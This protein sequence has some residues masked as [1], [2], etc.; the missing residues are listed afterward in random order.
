MT[1]SQ[2]ILIVDDCRSDRE[3]FRLYIQSSDINLQV[4]EASTF[5]EGL[6]LWHLHK[7]QITL[8][9]LSLP[10]G[11][12]MVFLS[13]IREEIA[14][15][16]NPNQK[17]P[18]VVLTGSEN[19]RDA[20][21]ALKLG[22]F[23]Y[24]VKNDINEFSLRYCIHGAI[25]HF[26]LTT[27]LENLRKRE[28][29]V[30][31]VALKVS[32][33]I[34]LEDICQT[35]V[36]EV[37]Q[38]L[39]ADRTLIYK[40][41]EQMKRRIVAESVAAPW[42]SCL[43]FG[44]ET[45]CV[46]PSE[47]QINEYL[48][49]KIYANP[50][51]HKAGFAECHL[52]MLE[53]FQVRANM[54]APIIL[55]GSISQQSQPILWGLMIV[56]HC[57]NTH[58]WEDFEI[59]LIQ[60][61]STQ[62]AIAIQQTELYRNL[63]NLNTSLEKQVQERT[64]ELQASQRKLRSIINAIPDMVNLVS[65]DGVYLECKR[66]TSFYDLIP[67][68][69][70]PIGKNIREFLPSDLAEAQLQ[71]VQKA[72]ATREML[73]IEQTFEVDGLCHYEEVRAMPV[74]TDTAVMIIRDITNRRHTEQELQLQYQRTQILAEVSLKIRQSLD[75]ETILLTAVGEIQ[76]IF[77]ASRVFIIQLQNDGAG[78]VLQELVTPPFQSVGKYVETPCFHNEY[79]ES[80]QRDR[81]VK[82]DN[83][84]APHMPADHAAFFRQFEVKANII[85][86]IIESE[87]LW[88]LLVIDQCDRPR[89]WTNFEVEL[90]QQVANQLA[91]AII[92]S[93]LLKAL[94]HSEQQRRLAT[95]LN[96][97][98][99]WSFDVATGIADWTSEHFQLMGLDPDTA[100]SNYV[101]WRDRVHPDDLAWVEAA[102]ENAI[103]NRTLLDLEYR[104]IHPDGSVYWVLT[105]GKGVY[106]SSGKAIKMVGV[107]MNI[108]DRKQTEIKLQKELVRNKAFLSNSFDGIVIL[109]TQ[110]QILEVNQS[111]ATML[112]YTIEELTQFQIHEIDTKW[113]K[114]EIT[115]SLADLQNIRNA[116]FETRHRRKN[117]SILDVEIS[118]NN[119]EIDGEML[120]FCI[121][122][123]VTQRKLYEQTLSRQE[124]ELRTLLENIPD[125]IA[126]F[127]RQL[128][129]T[130]INPAI[131]FFTDKPTDY[132]IN[133][134]HA[135]LPLPP[136]LAR[137][138]ESAFTTK[139]PCLVE[140]ETIIKGTSKYFQ[141][142]LVP[143][144]GTDGDVVSVTEISRNFTTQKLTEK[145]LEH[146]VQQEKMLNHF[147]QTIRNS[148]DVKVVFQMAI[149]AIANLLNLEQASIVQ[150]LPEQQ[151]WKHIAV[152]Q[153]GDSVFES[154]GVE[155]TDLDNPFAEMLKNKQFVQV[156]NTHNINDP[157]NR[158]LSE[159]KDSDGAWLLMPII[160][161][162]QTWGSLSLRRAYRAEHWQD[163][164]IEITQ[165][166]ANQLAI[167]IQQSS[168]YQQLQTKLEEQKQT[169]IALAKSKALADSAN[170]AKSDFL[171]NMS[172][173]LRTPMNGV[174]GMAQLLAN[175]PLNHA[176][177]NFVQ[178]ILDSGDALLMLINDILD[179]SKIE[180]GKLRLDNK[181]FK[182]EDTL[183]FVCSLL[184]KQAF[185]QNINL[186]CHINNNSA[187]NVIGDSS[188]LRQILINLIG[189]AIKF[190]EQGSVSISYSRK[191]I[192]SNVYEF[193]FAIADTGIGIDSKSINKLFRPFTQADASIN[194]QYGGTGLGLAICKRLVEMMNGR[195][196]VESG[197]KVGGHP[198]ADWVMDDTR[199]N[200]QG[201]TFH[202]TVRFPLANP[203]DANQ[204]Q[205][206]PLDPIPNNLAMDFQKF[207]LK[208]L[209]VEDNLLNQKIAAL[210]LQRLGYDADVVNNGSECL[211]ALE[212]SNTAT[213]YDVIFMDVQMPILNGLDTTRAIR[214]NLNLVQPWII[215]LTADAL[216]EDYQI[217]IDAGMNDYISKPIN[218]KEISRSLS[219]FIHQRV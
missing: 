67:S 69:V 131:T 32:Q 214:T 199:Q 15:Y 72:L 75:L 135:E 209:V 134:S 206:N 24:L 109:N 137:A 161:N 6:E 19:A 49:G 124:Q 192:K 173:E 200:Q 66:P 42:P 104:I 146:K 43:D 94:Q 83:V 163:N 37:R 193:K 84:D 53:G 1:N 176:Q 78:T 142:I 177:K 101:S 58:L 186:Q 185:D 87:N 213:N 36:H 210:M 61:V 8:M 68:K 120:Q 212:Q 23:D 208:I 162:D 151:I 171:A 123:D 194:R 33:F 170:K 60:Q 45:S 172:H 136:E 128:R 158:E 38:F 51:I 201:S 129:R 14:T 92:Q 64:S 205:E 50:D 31:R 215:A 46:T 190:T 57:A 198:P 77:Q 165:T 82:F 25:S 21:Q 96:Q 99:C 91:I 188:R 115:K 155:I 76:N 132:Y 174:L 22:A 154:V 145:A 191:L 70:D 89:Q 195:I 9:D 133:K 5:K 40:F 217:C 180:S 143:E 203:S 73:E 126:K 12:G 47:S 139:E 196:W 122:R 55:S 54:V 3:L 116:H 39:K 2:T 17:L 187:T 181:E 90:L 182:F 167:A 28:A 98:G 164:E 111:Y 11:N 121:C 13:K 59:K 197:G 184:S 48:D 34:N 79:L 27:K 85:T 153:D 26:N 102:F 44:S 144:I 114:T 74:E 117:G 152:F 207:P 166:I 149:N 211:A 103:A 159:K 107:M 52:Q 150:Y 105:K 35:V 71:A 218:L 219:E 62:V 81:V 65:V 175:T 63:Q 7:P 216:P 118:A 97:I 179:F 30:S 140:F 100:V 4:L 56:H 141:S 41:D 125:I 127:D 93:Q 112:G 95:D 108:N 183:N 202:F 147:V 86:P 157:V 10:D 80:Y 113:T 106:D 18:V 156:D 119:M 168:L 189:N 169:E 178:I 20:V 148:L 204:P 138:I 160:V 130:Y 29:I 16:N 110:G 88:G